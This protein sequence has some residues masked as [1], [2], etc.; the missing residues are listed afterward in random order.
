MIAEIGHLL[1]TA[2]KLGHFTLQ[3]TDPYAYKIYILLDFNTIQH[4]PITVTLLKS[5]ILSVV[6]IKKIFNKWASIVTLC[7]YFL[8][9]TMLIQAVATS[10]V[11]W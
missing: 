7:P 10:L 11:A 1:S 8:T 9:V 4:V 3:I 5:E 2:I 6:I